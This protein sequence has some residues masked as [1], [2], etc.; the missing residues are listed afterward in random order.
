MKIKLIIA[1]SFFFIDIE[2]SMALENI[3]QDIDYS[4]NVTVDTPVCTLHLNDSV[5]YLGT[6]PS[7]D[8]KSNRAPYTSF[9]LYFN[10]CKNTSSGKISLAGEHIRVDN[11]GSLYLENKDCDSCAGG[12]KLNLYDNEKK[13][14]TA[15]GIE[16]NLTNVNDSFTGY[17]NLVNTDNEEITPGIIDTSVR[18]VIQYN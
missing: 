3:Q 17:V 2:A 16:I 18:I 12:V 15:D 9:V 8:I 10:N 13:P 1:L 4:L 14:L 11:D 7:S 5:V 6:V